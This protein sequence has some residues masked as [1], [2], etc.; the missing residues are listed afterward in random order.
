MCGGGWRAAEVMTFAQVMGLSST[1][2]YSDGWIGWSIDRRN[3][4]ETG[5]IRAGT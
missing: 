3:P 1:S 5:P 4:V 2:L